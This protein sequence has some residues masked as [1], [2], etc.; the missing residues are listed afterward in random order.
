MRIITQY[1]PQKLRKVLSTKA[2]P[3]YLSEAAEL[4]KRARE[5]N[6]INYPYFK[7]R[8]IQEAQRFLQFANRELQ[9]FGLESVKI[10]T[11]NGPSVCWYLNSGDAYNP[12]VLWAEGKIR[13]GTLADIYQK[14]EVI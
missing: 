5:V 6:S 9:M 11:K 12:T 4:I 8:N 7:N 14:W 13:V 3:L 1:T 2:Y 10:R